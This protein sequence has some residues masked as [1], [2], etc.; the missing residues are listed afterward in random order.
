MSTSAAALAAAVLLLCQDASSAVSRADAAR[1]HAIASLHRRAAAAAPGTEEGKRVAAELGAFGSAD[2]RDGRIGSATELLAEAY[3]LDGDNGL[4]LAELTLAHARGEDFD[5]ARFYL[6]LAEQRINRAPPEIYAV[7]GQVY[8]A[9]NR[10]DDAIAA[11]G[12]AVRFGGQ[13]PPMLRSLARARD[14]LALTR[15][16]RTRARENFSIF[17]DPTIPEELLES[18]GAVLEAAYR[19][20]SA[21]LGERLPGPQ[22]VVLYAGRSYFA[23]ASVPDWVSGFY[24]GKIRIS[25]EPDERP[26][27]VLAGVLAHEL[28]HALIRRRSGG[29]APAWLQEGLAQWCEGRRLP[30]REIAG[31]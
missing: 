19:E 20:E 23:L 26:D 17:A 9:L 31:I 28:A 14:E 18:V 1:D 6:R 10:L 11:W 4:L 22:V 3:A 16:Q 2:L 13:D 12:E 30:R 15:G 29:R 27:Y 25:I 21:L 24:D 8:Y 7:L 5:G